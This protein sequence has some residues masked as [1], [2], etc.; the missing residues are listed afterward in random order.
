MS[1]LVS[2]AFMKLFASEARG[3]ADDR[4][5]PHALQQFEENSAPFLGI[6]DCRSGHEGD[7]MGHGTEFRAWARNF[8]REV[9]ASS[10][11]YIACRLRNKCTVLENCRAAGGRCWILK[12]L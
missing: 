5:F 4:M 6:R 10:L 1:T 12:R 11:R 3:I 8:D 2:T 7:S 9:D